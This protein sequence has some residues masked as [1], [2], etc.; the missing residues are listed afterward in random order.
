M[1]V[2][3][4]C[5]GNTD[6]IALSFVIMGMVMEIFSCDVSISKMVTPTRRYRGI[7]AGLPSR[8][9][10][11]PSNLL[12]ILEWE[13]SGKVFLLVLMTMERSS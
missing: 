4:K 12:G 10:Y 13:S 6:A 1:H 3:V 9:T 8:E 11:C 5:N 2:I 7:F